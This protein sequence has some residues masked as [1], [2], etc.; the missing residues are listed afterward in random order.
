M[1]SNLFPF[2][3][4][5][6]TIITTLLLTGTAHAQSAQ[7]PPRTDA[8]VEID[9]I[10]VTGSRIKRAATEGPAP[11]TVITSEQM[12]REGFATVH[13]ALSTLTEAIGPIEP[14]SRWGQSSSNAYPLNLR[15]L[16]PGRSLLLINGHRMADYPMPYQGKSNFANFNNIPSGIVERVEILSGSASAIY[17]SDAMGGVVN[18]ILK[19]HA[20]EHVARVRWGEATRGGSDTLDIALSGGLTFAGTRGALVYN[21]QHFDRKI[22]LA[23]DRP[24]MDEEFD[25]NY[26]VWGPG[27][28]FWNVPLMRPIAGMFLIDRD[29]G[30][31]INPPEGG[32]TCAQYGD[33]YYLAQAYNYNRNAGTG[34]VSGSYCAINA[35]KNWVLRTGSQ[36]DSGYLYGTFDFT[37][38][39]QG[40]TA[41]GLWHSTGDSIT[42]L[43]QF[44]SLNYWDPDANNGA[45]GVR[46][47]RR[48][49]SPDEIGGLDHVLTKSRE[50][51]L[52][53]SA[54]LRGQWR[55]LDWEATL[56]RAT[57]EVRESFP[58]LNR[59]DMRNFFLGPELGTATDA[60]GQP[61]PIHRPHYDR[62][63]NPIALSDYQAFSHT[64]VKRSRTWLNQAQFVV[65]GELFDGWA[66]PIGFAA[67][68]EAGSQ[69]YRMLPEPKT[70]ID[71]EDRWTPP[72]GRLD[73]GH[74]K[75]DRYAAGVEFR[76]P[77]LSRMEINLAARYDQYKALV[78]ADKVTWQAGLEWRPVDTLLMRASYGTSFRAPDMHY[79]YASDTTSVEDLFD[80]LGCADGGWPGMR[81][82]WEDGFKVEDANMLRRG[83]PDLRY[84]EGKSW[85]AGMVWD[86]FNGFSVS[87]DY[88]SIHIDN[89]VD[90]FTAN[91]LLLD[92]AY[93]QRNG[94]DPDGRVRTVPPS[95]AWCAEVASRIT[96][97]PGVPANVARSVSIRTSPINRA[98]TEVTGV[99][100]SARYRLP[101][102]R[103]G[104]WSFT[105]NYT[106]MLGYKT[107]AFPTD[108]LLD[109]RATQN[110]RTRLNI[111][112]NWVHAR[113]TATL[114]M[115]QKSGGR[116]HRWG[117][118]A[119]FADG[120]VPSPNANCL[121]ND[122]ASP[123]FGQSTQRLFDRRPTRRYFNGSIGYAF[124][125][126]LRINLYASN[127]FD[128]IYGDQWQGNFAYF[129]DDPVGREVAAEI[130]YTF[131]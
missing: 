103:V 65:N 22:L 79:I 129:I 118:C 57:Y 99:D 71:D 82:T 110:P 8:A 101:E 76:V 87:A 130:V 85:S 24:F 123:T 39:L 78:S 45:G 35:Y 131:R 64:G 95:A 52:D 56:G 48:F 83:T 100:A 25:R 10:T 126:E 6:T 17:G 26:A 46:A 77:V 12:K 74:G 19:E 73:Q 124:S 109:S 72:F 81:C 92:E 42:F 7:Q 96:R 13:D 108:P 44:N 89:L 50:T 3:S 70:L 75:R 9:G 28:R 47:L 112:A 29:T 58:T 23:K 121:D 43:E 18:V 59:G 41:L 53:L 2:R 16:G 21:V 14:D 38:N 55:R 69:G 119:P 84:E 127:L 54:G 51:A 91:Q 30:N 33:T 37:P 68:L 114:L 36:D 88:W 106:N 80:Y 40:W 94:F 63:W 27:E 105:L 66:G 125:D 34:S 5:L 1:N 49:F 32:V 15:N 31:Y 120:Y 11:I 4:P 107:R 117:G 60:D 104:S 62:L 116:H 97:T 115:H 61:I 122:T 67:V 93:C 98:E 90:D 128:K 20:D 111:S 113:W 102:T 86:A